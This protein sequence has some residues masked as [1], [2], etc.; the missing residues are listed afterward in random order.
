MKMVLDEIDHFHP[1]FD[2]SAPDHEPTTSHSRDDCRER[3]HPRDYWVSHDVQNSVWSSGI[4]RFDH[5]HDIC[6]FSS[7]GSLRPALQ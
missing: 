6:T 3:L 5:D 2:E 4:T 1:N 7:H